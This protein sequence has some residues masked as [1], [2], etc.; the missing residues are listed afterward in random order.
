MHSVGRY[1]YHDGCMKC[2]VCKRSS[3]SKKQPQEWFIHNDQPFCRHHYSLLHA[4]ICPGCQQAVLSKPAA[5][6]IHWHHEC[7]MIQKYWNIRLATEQLL[8]K[9]TTGGGLFA[10]SVEEQLRKVQSE[11]DQRRRQVWEEMRAFEDS[12]ATCIWDM[13]LHVTA[14]SVAEGL[15]MA[16]QLTWH[17]KVLLTAHQAI[18]ENGKQQGK[19]KMIYKEKKS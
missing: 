3:S 19:Y 6:D 5:T 15:Q 17:L 1:K 4:P 14:R 12:L 10:P 2:A 7:F 16:S 13:A 18:H 11:M 8:L 9:K